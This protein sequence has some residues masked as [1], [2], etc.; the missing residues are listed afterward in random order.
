MKRQ[1]VEEYVKERFKMKSPVDEYVL[2]TNKEIA[3]KAG[4]D[5]SKYYKVTEKWNNGG[6]TICDPK[7]GNLTF[8]SRDDFA[9]GY[10][11]I[12]NDRLARRNRLRTDR[13]YEVTGVFRNYKGE[14][15]GVAI[16]RDDLSSCSQIVISRG[17][18]TFVNPP[19][20]KDEESKKE[21]VFVTNSLLLEKYNLDKYKMYKVVFRDDID[22]DVIG[23]SIPTCPKEFT[24]FLCPGQYSYSDPNE[25][26]NEPD[27][28]NHPSHYE[29]GKF[30][31]IEVME[32]ALGRD[33]VKGFCIGNAFK[34]LYRAKRKNG[35][36]D[37]K[38]ARWYL[39]K[40]ISMEEEDN[41]KDPFADQKKRLKD[42]ER[43]IL[44]EAN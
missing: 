3:R 23:I 15:I 11:H 37:M 44:N 34:Y 32:E 19:T 4:I 25:P 22:E 24:L 42:L 13:I 1:S 16:T 9:Y 17:S 12:V 40:V 20:D 5:L 41:L 28:V 31:C 26:K 7:T 43:K 33:V 30:E 21:Y 35:L 27:S 2:V 18:Y 38:K 29:T 8:L 14:E 36:E 39:D 10:I 6:V